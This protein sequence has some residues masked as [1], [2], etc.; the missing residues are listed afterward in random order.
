MQKLDWLSFETLCLGFEEE[1]TSVVAYLS[2]ML[3]VCLLACLLAGWLVGCFFFLKKNKMVSSVF[4]GDYE[5]FWKSLLVGI[6]ER[7]A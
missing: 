2:G 5:V 7:S 4:F 1:S 3:F 6:V